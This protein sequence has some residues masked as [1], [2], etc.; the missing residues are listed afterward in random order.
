[1][2]AFGLWAFILAGVFLNISWFTGGGADC[3][4]F[5]YAPNSGLAYSPGHGV[6]YYA[7]GVQI[8]GIASLTGAINLIVTILNMRAPGM[9]LMR[10][11]PFTWMALVTQFLLVFSLPVITVALILL[12]FDRTFDANFF[13]VDQGADPL[14]WQHLFWI[15]GHPEVYILILPAFGIVSD[16][17][18]VFSRKPL[19]GYPFVVFSGIAI[20]F[21]GWGVWA[22]HMFA[23][24]LGPVS[25]AAFALT[26]MF[27][28]VPT[29]VK[30]LNWLA[31]M[32]GG[33]IR[34]TVAALFSISLVAMFTIGGL[35]GVMHSIAGSDTQ[36]TDTYFIV[37]HFHYVLFGGALQGLFAGVYYW[38]P[39][40]FGHML[41]EKLGKWHFWFVIIGFNLTFGPF[42]LVG[43]QGQPRRTYRYDPELGLGFWNMVS[44]IGAFTIAAG[45][46]IFFYNVWYSKR[47]APPAP[48]DP[49][50]G[51]TLEWSIP[52]PAPEHNF[53]YVPVV[54]SLDDF[55]NKKYRSEGGHGPLVKVADGNEIAQKGDQHP[56]LPSPS[57]W[58]LVVAAGL[59]I[60]G[61]GIIYTPVLIVIGLLVIVGG[62]YGWVLE[63]P[64]DPDGDG[65]GHG[66]HDGPDDAAHAA[67]PIET[68][69]H[70]GD[71]DTA[72]HDGDGD[73]AEPD[74]RRRP[75]VTDTASAEVDDRD[76]IAYGPTEWDEYE[77]LPT[78]T[79][80][81]HNKVAMWTFLGSE[82]LLFGALIS[83]Y[84]LARNR[85]D[86]VQG[87]DVGD[88]G[89]PGP[90]AS[91][92]FD[93]PFTSVSSFVLLMSSLTMA[94]AVASISR[95]DQRRLRLWLVTT[96]ILGGIF[97]GGQVY[98]FTTFYREG[99]G[100]T[101][102]ISASAF[103]TLTG[104]HGVHVTV[105]IIMLCSLYYLARKGA[106]P[107]EREETVEIAGLYWHF[108]DIVWIVIFAVV[109][110]IP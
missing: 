40:A 15:F 34:F 26:T 50:D 99:M 61:F 87:F 100:F 32:W 17:L 1:M 14:L 60:L 57:Y 72:G 81:S 89:D 64:T 27:I 69:G 58:P 2:N 37:A 18:P 85:P 96:A 110:L 62:A 39:K 97:I 70:D 21:M 6:D 25:V 23:S 48:P 8:A 47:H 94:M 54:D 36:Q 86:I 104:F 84:L 74:P 49:W 44:T 7:V 65:H 78:S 4:W 75:S 19:F 3:G 66:D 16:T 53:D 56:H 52:S 41:N 67:S 13:N 109:Y 106:M 95:G 22:H 68:A 51:R 108:V 59:P 93:I 29:G 80:L 88:G 43:L 73:T 76:E 91:D 12:T 33:N 79:G 83:T 105:G 82:C 28:A 107:T 42:H 55:W 102:N 63:P 24:G 20:G 38:Y 11:P 98:E 103:Y 101:S 45:L 90:K 31:T 35:S 9:T 77:H 30:I 10:M 71:G 46:L 5:C 92:L